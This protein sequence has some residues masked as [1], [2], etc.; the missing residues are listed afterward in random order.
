MKVFYNI[1]WIS[2]KL[3]FKSWSVHLEMEEQRLIN[4]P[5]A[6]NPMHESSYASKDCKQ[7]IY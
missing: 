7:D 1:F 5:T 2:I 6:D 4:G 3:V